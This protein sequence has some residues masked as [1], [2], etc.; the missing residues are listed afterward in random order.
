MRSRWTGRSAIFWD[1]CAI[2]SGGLSYILS[3]WVKSPLTNQ[4]D[5]WC[6]GFPGVKGPAQ[7][8]PRGPP[9]ASSTSRA[10]CIPCSTACWARG[11]RH[12]RRPPHAPLRR[13][14]RPLEHLGQLRADAQ[15]ERASGRGLKAVPESPRFRPESPAESPPREVA[16]TPGSI[17][18]ILILPSWRRGKMR[19]MLNWQR[20]ELRRE[21]PTIGPDKALKRFLHELKDRKS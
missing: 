14:L 7:A 13:G 1:C 16:G 10:P 5:R 20:K 2:K 8:V 17:P 18:N 9:S 3:A 12:L 21:L 11:L 15:S 19:S 4:A 6:N